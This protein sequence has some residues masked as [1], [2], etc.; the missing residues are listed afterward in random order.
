MHEI[1]SLDRRG[2]REFGL[3]TGAIFVALFG[4]FFPWVFEFDVP[5]WPWILGL[6]LAVWG[7]LAPMTLNPVYRGWMHFGL[8]LSRI[9]TPLVL[10][11]VFFLMIF[12]LGFVMRRFGWDPMARKIDDTASSYRIRSSKSEKGRFERPF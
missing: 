12:P 3:V 11:A 1:P 9:T 10:G 8:L 2:L 6:I 7:L 5:I 4:L